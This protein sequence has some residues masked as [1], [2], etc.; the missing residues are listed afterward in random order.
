MKRYLCLALCV[1][2]TVAQRP[3]YWGGDYASAGLYSL[4]V[5][6]NLTNAISNTPADKLM[7]SSET[8]ISQIRSLQK[9][10][11]VLGAGGFAYAYQDKIP[12][13][14]DSDELAIETSNMLSTFKND[15]ISQLEMLYQRRGKMDCVPNLQAAT[16]TLDIALAAWVNY[17]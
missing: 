5:A 17:F 8:F 15:L 9:N 1:V 10:L 6:Y 11:D 13:L 14:F 4:G 7:N 16:D 2:C 12:S 3:I